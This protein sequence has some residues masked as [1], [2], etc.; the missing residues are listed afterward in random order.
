MKLIKAISQA[1]GDKK[2]IA[3]DLGVKIP[4]VVE[5]LEKS[6]FPGMKVLS[7][8]LMETERMNIYHIFG[9]KYCGLWWNS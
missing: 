7:L 3:E 4:E 5:V 1:I 8:H 2:I 9:Q 6:G